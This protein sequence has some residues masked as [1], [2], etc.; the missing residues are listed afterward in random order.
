MTRL[1]PVALGSFGQL[2]VKLNVSAPFHCK[3]M[4]PAAQKL[5]D[6]MIDLNQ[7]VEVKTTTSPASFR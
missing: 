5:R 3:L 4:H 6:Y 2:S 1:N 7:K